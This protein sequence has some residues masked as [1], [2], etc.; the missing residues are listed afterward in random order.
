MRKSERAITASEEIRSVIDRSQ[1]V[2]LGLFGGEYP[3][4]VPL[5]FGYEVRD[6]KIFV[7]FHCA[8]EG[9]KIDCMARDG[10]VCLEF[11]LFHGYVETGH[12]L[13]ADYESVIAF[14]RASLCQG[15]E[16]VRGI[17]LLLEHTG[18]TDYSAQA[19]AAL[20][21]V[22]VCKVVCDRITGKRRFPKMAE[23][24]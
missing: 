13:T 4:V 18:F 15:E 7:Y 3:Y 2:R 12:S 10:R 19:C 14:G 24:S 20:P 23:M 16:K 9:K 21:V 6:G 5:S 1:V 22:E 8:T 17:R 11:D